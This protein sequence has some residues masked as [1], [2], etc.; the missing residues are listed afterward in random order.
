MILR[1]GSIGSTKPNERSR[2][3]HFVS[4]YCDLS[5]IAPSGV[6]LGRERGVLCGPSGAGPGVLGVM[7]VVSIMT[8]IKL[9][10]VDLGGRQKIGKR[11]ANLVK[12]FSICCG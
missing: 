11:V 10:L 12:L 6:S 4:F 3:S 5:D 8:C 2:F 1:L 9:G 7:C